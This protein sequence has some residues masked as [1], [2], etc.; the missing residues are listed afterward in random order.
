[1]ARYSGATWRPVPWANARDD[2]TE[3]TI[4][5]LHV[6]ATNAASQFNYF[7]TSRK[8]C[9]HFHVALD[10]DVE[11]Y[12]DTDKLSAADYE[13]SDN[14]ISIETAGL[15]DGEWTKAQ[16]AAL[17]KLLAWIHRAHDIPLTLKTTSSQSPGI[18]W[19]RL[20][21]TGNF[22][23]LPSILAGRNQ[24]GYAGE[25]W[26][27]SGGKVCPGD[28]RIKQIPALVAAAAGAP[29]SSPEDDMPLAADERKWLDDL[30]RLLLREFT[31]GTQTVDVVDGV[32]RGLVVDRRN[33]AR[34][35]EL[36]ASNRAQAAA[37]QALATSAG[38]DPKAV[39]ATLDKAVSAALA[40]FKI[41]LSTE[42]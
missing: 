29:T 17:V 31:D 41:T 38:L 1:M 24:R 19:H 11:Q 13:G 40:D 9:S 14:A 2:N 15:G 6:T 8:A 18:G 3:A 36:V 21:I 33:E 25:A 16:F 23:S 32:R 26:S 39:T 28:K 35:Q 10:G 37:I 30:H 27:L 22:P 20:G 42:A 12:I 7:L 4:V 5:V 34:L